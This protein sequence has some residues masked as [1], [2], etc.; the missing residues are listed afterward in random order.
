[1]NDDRVVRDLAPGSAA[2]AAGV[3]NG[4][5]IVETSDI[6]EVRKDETRPLTL[7]LR[8][9]EAR[10]TVTYLPRGAPVEGYRWARDPATPD[11]KCRF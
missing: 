2:E 8:R 5:V 6:N 3:K 9:G 1:M 11:T 7:T 10:T 4:D